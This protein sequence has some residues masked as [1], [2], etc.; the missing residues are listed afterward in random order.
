M[1]RFKEFLEEK[2]LVGKTFRKKKGNKLVKILGIGHNKVYFDDNGTEVGMNKNLFLHNY[3]EV[4]EDKKIVTFGWTILRFDDDTELMT[5]ME[6]IDKNQVQVSLY[7]EKPEI[8]KLNPNKDI[9]KQL[10]KLIGR[11]LDTKKKD[12][13]DFI[14][15]YPCA[16]K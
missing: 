3:E 13:L 8:H 12:V 5:N 2:M 11:K 7:G 16:C 9:K 6:L 10:E 1:I 4:N 15:L 14:E